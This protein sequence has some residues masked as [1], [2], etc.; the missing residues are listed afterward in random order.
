MAGSHLLYLSA[1]KSIFARRLVKK[2]Q[3]NADKSFCVACPL[4]RLFAI[5]EYVDYKNVIGITGSSGT[6]ENSSFIF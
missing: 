6:F 4:V 2:R 5:Y 1:K 3:K